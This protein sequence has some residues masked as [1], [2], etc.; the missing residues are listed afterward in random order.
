MTYTATLH[1]DPE[2]IL[3]ELLDTAWNLR[4]SVTNEGG[5]NPH[6]YNTEKSSYYGSDVGTYVYCGRIFSNQGW[7]HDC[8][9]SFH[10]WL[11]DG[12]T[13][14]W[15][16]NGHSADNSEENWGTCR[17]MYDLWY[18]CIAEVKARRR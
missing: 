10:T 7:F 4:R 17:A 1:G 18:T 9:I 15:S 13:K 3:E 6:L 8:G 11:K 2:T 12:K 5:G 14:V 16:R